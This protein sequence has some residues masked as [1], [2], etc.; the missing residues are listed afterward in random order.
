MKHDIFSCFKDF[1]LLI[2]DQFSAHIKIFRFD[3]DTE[4]MS[5]DMSKYL[6]SN[7]IMHQTSCVGT[8]QQNGISERKNRDLLEITR[9]IMLQMN[10]PKHFWSRCLAALVSCIYQLL[11]G[12][13]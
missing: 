13:N 3:N 1:Y 6:H 7:G 11:T 10:V 12:I 4:Y 9:A 8:P 2:L 5:K